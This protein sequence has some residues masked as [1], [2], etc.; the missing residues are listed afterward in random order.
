MQALEE[1]GVALGG[2]EHLAGQR[3]VEVR[4]MEADRLIE[5]G[6]RPRDPLCGIVEI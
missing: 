2:I 6:I 5:V 4:Q 1:R 3:P